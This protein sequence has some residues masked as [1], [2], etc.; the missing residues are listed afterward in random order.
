MQ[1]KRARPLDAPSGTAAAWRSDDDYTLF[2]A[3]VDR[4]LRQLGLSDGTANT[5]MAA[6]PVLPVMSAVGHVLQHGR[7]PTTW[8]SRFG[9]GCRS[10][11]GLGARAAA[12]ESPTRGELRTAATSNRLLPRR[13]P[14]DE[15]ARAH[16]GDDC[17]Q[18]LGNA[19]P[20]PRA[21]ATRRRPS[22][23]APSTSWR[24]ARLPEKNCHDVTARRRA[25]Q[26]R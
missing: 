26:H 12:G 16:V 17:G 19:D 25:R 21:G 9:I 11:L 7:Y 3:T 8:Q 14:C 4:V 10:P 24:A 15:I 20:G 5:V 22:I 6:L 23:R 1:K 18:Y 13:A 2:G